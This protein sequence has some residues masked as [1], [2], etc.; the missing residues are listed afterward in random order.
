MRLLRGY[1]RWAG[2]SANKQEVFSQRGEI[3]GLDGTPVLNA[4]SRSPSVFSPPPIY[5]KRFRPQ[6]K[7]TSLNRHALELL[8]SMRLSV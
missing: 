8:I 6:K 1:V 3:K 4:S 5:F 7:T 2:K